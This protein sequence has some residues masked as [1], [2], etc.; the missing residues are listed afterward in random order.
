MTTEIQQTIATLRQ[1]L[2]DDPRDH[3]TANPIFL[4]QQ[5]TEIG[6]IADGY[7]EDH[8]DWVDVESGDHVVTTVDELAA[9]IREHGIDEDDTYGYAADDVDQLLEDLR[10]D[11]VSGGQITIPGEGSYRRFGFVHAWEYVTAHFTREAAEQHIKTNGHN[12]RSPR[13]YVMSQQRSWEWCDVRDGIERGD[14]VA[15]DRER[16]QAILDAFDKAKE[17]LHTESQALALLA[18]HGSAA[19]EALREIVG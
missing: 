6:P 2:R 17:G 9:L 18:Q 16:I 5:L 14:V 7:H 1:R 19:L 13:V 8:H 10:N 12:L 15:I 3:I 11:R 4:V